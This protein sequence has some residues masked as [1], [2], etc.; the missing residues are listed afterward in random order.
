MLKSLTLIETVI[1]SA[2]L[3]VCLAAFLSN[4]LML[5]ILMD[6]SRDITLAKNAVQ[7]Q[8]EEM[9]RIDFGNLLA[10]N[11]TTFNLPGFL[12][13]RGI[14]K[15]EVNSVSGHP[16]LREVRIIASFRSRSRAIGEDINFNGQLDTGE[17]ANNNGRLD[18]P[19]EMVTLIAR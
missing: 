5:F 13:A 1:A 15:I 17:D 14:G 2:I 8:M 16:D 7:A 19:V 12:A 11:G 6:L 10:Q 18:S 3:L 4:F 9:H